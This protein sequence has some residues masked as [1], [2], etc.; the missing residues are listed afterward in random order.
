MTSYR[1]ECRFCLN[2]L[3]DKKS[4]IINDEIRTQFKNVCSM[5]LIDSE[6][7]SKIICEICL[8]SLNLAHTVKEE[9]CENQ[10]KLQERLI[11]NDTPINEHARAS[12]KRPYNA[13]SCDNVDEL[14]SIIKIEDDEIVEVIDETDNQEEYSE[15][16]N[17]SS[18]M[19]TSNIDWNCTQLNREE[20]KF[21]QKIN[22]KIGNINSTVEAVLKMNGYNSVFSFQG[23]FATC[24]DNNETINLLEQ[25]VRA[26]KISSQHLQHIDINGKTP[27][28]FTFTMGQRCEIIGVFEKIRNMIQYNSLEEELGL[29]SKIQNLQHVVEDVLRRRL[30]RKTLG[31][32]IH[33]SSI[34]K[35]PYSVWIPCCKCQKL[36]IVTISELSKPN[37]EKKLNVRT[38]SY[39][40]HVEECDGNML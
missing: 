27:G 21:W 30:R 8:R 2:F 32:P 15:S 17:N 13:M 5:E 20:K 28:D 26:L 24:I 39:V 35:F 11:Q 6:M 4:T 40:K 19:E 31:F 12:R 25:S 14:T 36:Q 23:H 18:Q 37:G 33:K 9:F 3:Q 16:D 22:E 29:E 38:L 1:K 10:R 34:E 7:F